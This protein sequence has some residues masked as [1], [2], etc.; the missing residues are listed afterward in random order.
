MLRLLLDEHISPAVA[1]ELRQQCPEL[2]VVHRKDWDDGTHQG[3]THQGLTH[4]GFWTTG[5]RLRALKENLTLVTYDQLSLASDLKSW[6]QW[7]WWISGV[8]FVDEKAITPGD[9]KGLARA[10]AAVWE[11]YDQEDW[12]DCILYLT[13]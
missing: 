11:D 8:I 1:R 10:L 6:A 3:L 2:F 4:Q 13:P 7:G 5:L 9:F 12:G